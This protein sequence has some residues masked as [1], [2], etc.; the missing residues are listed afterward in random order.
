MHVGFIML[1]HTALDRAAAVAR[2]WADDGAPVVVHVDSRV[3][4]EELDAMQAAC[5][6]SA[7]ISFSRRYAC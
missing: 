6:G 5:A 1:C 3:A 7:D 2:Y 4:R